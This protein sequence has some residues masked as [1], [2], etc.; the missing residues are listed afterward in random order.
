MDPAGGGLLS[1]DGVGASGNRALVRVL[2]S[3]A[4]GR[5]GPC[6]GTETGLGLPLSQ[7]RGALGLGWAEIDGTHADMYS[8]WARLD[9]DVR[10]SGG[11]AICWN[12]SLSQFHSESTAASQHSSAFLIPGNLTAE[13]GTTACGS[14]GVSRWE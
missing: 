9:L 4:S 11:R 7:R 1:W 5:K 10:V 3:P 2:I 6:E 8:V 12:I 13:E 14:R